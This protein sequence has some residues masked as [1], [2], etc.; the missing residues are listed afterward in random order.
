MKVGFELVMR[1]VF[2]MI[3]FNKYGEMLFVVVILVLI[4]VV[5]VRIEMVSLGGSKF[6]VL[7][8]FDESFEFG[9]IKLVDSVF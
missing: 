4:V 9:E 3:V 2:D 6:F 8:F 1:V 7:L 5:E